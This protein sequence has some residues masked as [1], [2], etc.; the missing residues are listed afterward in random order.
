MFNSQPLGFYCPSQPVVAPSGQP[1]LI[2]HARVTEKST[3]AG[4]ADHELV[5][6]S[7]P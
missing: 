2:C 6:P 1:P 4:A 3:P 7:T 5:R